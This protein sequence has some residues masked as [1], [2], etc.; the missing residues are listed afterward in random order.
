MR[1]TENFIVYRYKRWGR[2]LQFDDS[3]KPKLKQLLH[4]LSYCNQAGKTPTRKQRLPKV[5][6]TFEK[7]V[8]QKKA[9]IM[10]DYDRYKPC[11]ES[12]RALPHDPYATYQPTGNQQGSHAVYIGAVGPSSY[13]GDAGP[14]IDQQNN[15]GGA[16]PSS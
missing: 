16:G 12:S 1:L 8:K 4:S 13:L 7:L 15:P 5:H 9:S 11:Y 14:S 3:K 6:K 2:M 10:E